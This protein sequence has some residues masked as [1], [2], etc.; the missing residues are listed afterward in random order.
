MNNDCHH[1]KMTIKVERNDTWAHILT[2][3]LAR[4]VRGA[5]LI[6]VAISRFKR[7]F[8]EQL[9]STDQYHAVQDA[10]LFG[11]ANPRLVGICLTRVYVQ[12]YCKYFPQT[13]FKRICNHIAFSK[14]DIPS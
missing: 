7:P 9:F 6:F 5:A 11:Y 3:I 14:R 13:S 10:P 12:S 2:D 4:P 1:K 8:L